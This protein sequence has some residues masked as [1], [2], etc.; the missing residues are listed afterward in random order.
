[1]LT[2]AQE[3]WSVNLSVNPARNLKRLKE[4]KSRSKRLTAQEFMQLVNACNKSK[5]I[6]LKS[7]FSLAIETGMR[8]GELLSLTKDM[9]NLNKRIIFLKDTKNGSA[10]TVPLSEKAIHEIKVY[11]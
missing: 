10:R 5:C 1:M 8:R 7:L 3:L 6:W 11:L 4:N 9:I 2:K